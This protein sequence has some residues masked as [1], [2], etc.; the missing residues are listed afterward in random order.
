MGRASETIRVVLVALAVSAVPAGGTD[1]PLGHR[2]SVSRY[3]GQPVQGKLFKL[4]IKAGQQGNPLSLPLPGNPAGTTSAVLIDRD[5]GLLADSL[6]AGQ[7]KGLGNPPGSRGWKYRNKSAPAG[8]RVRVLLVKERTIT[9]VAKGTGSMPV[10][11]G[12]SGAIRTV[13]SLGGE[14]YCTEAA[15]PHLKEVVGKLIKTG[16]QAAPVTCPVGCLL[17]V[18]SDGDRLDDCIETSTGIFVDAFDTGTDPL[19]PDTDHDG[20]D[21]GDEVLG[22]E[23]GLDLPGLGVSPLRRDL[24]AEYDWF[25]DALECGAHSHRP[26]DAALDLVTA[27]F[28]AAPLVN[29][30]GTTGINFIHDRGQGGLLSGGNLIADP[31]GVL[32]G[33]VGNLEFQTYKN[34][35]FASERFGYFHYVIL[36]HR[37]DT[38]SDSS[39]QAEI[40]GDDM[41]VSLYCANS[42]YNVAHTIAHELGHNLR[43]LHGGGDNCN[44]K[45][46]YNSVMNYRYQFPGIDSNCTPPG[47]GVLDYSIG[48]RLS[49]DENDLDENAGVCGAPPWDWNG[50]SVIETSVAFDLN[51]QEDFPVLFCGAVLATLND[52]DDWA[53]LSLDVLPSPA[54]GAPRAPSIVIDCDNPAP[55]GR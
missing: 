42:D 23:N 31:D 19:D 16:S 2:V 44:Y 35:N 40:L 1:H 51:P 10:P 47:D 50:N 20:I 5:G 27:M 4:V 14:R 46:N 37:Y 22:A 25:D 53:N 33:G 32:V 21:D 52:H 17:G 15:A 13:L 49:L 41:I 12:A 24:L 43:L 54:P 28:A 9:L 48:D 29:P 18:D 34:A 38:N 6:T 8:G 30:D 39:G 55:I 26:T 45:P 11:N 36:P 7:W 3:G